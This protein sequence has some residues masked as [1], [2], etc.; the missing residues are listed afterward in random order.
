MG[1]FEL[2][3]QAVVV[4]TGGIGA[5]HDIVRQYWP[6][7]LGTPPAEMVTGVPAYVD[8]RMLDISAEGGRHELVNRDRMWHYTEGLQNWNPVWPG[9]GIRILPGP[10]SLWFDALGRRLSDPCLPG[11]R[12][13]STPSS[14][15]GRQRTWRSTTTPGSS[16]PRRSSRRSSRSRAPSR[17]P[18]SPPRTRRRCCAT[19]CSARARPARWTPS[20]ARVRTS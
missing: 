20:C 5:N 12:T 14:T 16:S 18:T 11:C 17:T 2:T 13:P 8:G 6:E 1:E 7:R 10:S 9:H 15:C 19:G 3:A 4:T